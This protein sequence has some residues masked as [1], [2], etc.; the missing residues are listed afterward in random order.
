MLVVA[1]TAALL[2]LFA[3]AVP[4]T[5]APAPQASLV[6][7]F[8]GALASGIENMP[9]V[10]MGL[11]SALVCGLL[12]GWERESRGKSAGLRTNMLICIGACMYMMIGTFVSLPGVPGSDPSRVGA[13][14]VSGIGFLGAGT[15]IRGRVSVHG[16]TSAAT[17]WVAAAVGLFCGSG[18]PLEALVFTVVL[19]SVLVGLGRIES[20]LIGPCDHRTVEVLV[21]AGDERS[22]SVVGGLFEQ[23]LWGK[24]TL[25]WTVEEEGSVLRAPLCREHI[26][27]RGFL[28]EVWQISGV[29]RIRY[30]DGTVP[31]VPLG[32][33]D[34]M[35]DTPFT[36]AGKI[37][38]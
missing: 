35:P 18:Y 3:L 28:T 31:F 21:E 20:L 38:K 32:L 26:A 22:Q 2:P 30:D 37:R 9:H 36:P 11:A 12:I 6:D 13:Q 16:L 14:V 7:E 8:E 19:L 27:H 1:V 5:E 23:N 10:I 15:I 24:Q 4:P 25:A 34:E 29:R 17:I 33:D